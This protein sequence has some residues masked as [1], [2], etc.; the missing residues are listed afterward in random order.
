MAPP[1]KII[2]S[3]DVEGLKQK[4]EEGKKVLHGL[5][6]A[7]LDDSFSKK[8]KKNI[9][10]ELEKGA[11]RIEEDI[12]G[13]RDSLKKMGRAGEAAFDSGKVKSMLGA[14]SEMQVRLKDIKSAQAGM[15]GGAGGAGGGGGMGVGGA[16]RMAKGGLGMV[17]GILGVGVGAA[18]LT[19]RQ[20]GVSQENLRIRALTGG[21]TVSGESQFG[22]T[23]Q[24]RRQRAAEIA[25]SIGRDI[26]A[27][28]LNKVTDMGEK[29]ERAF[30]ITS[31]DQVGAMAAA[32]RAGGQGEEFFSNAIGVA[33]ASGLEGGRV[34][35]FLQSMTQSL[36][37]MS[38][39]VN[40]DTASL[41]GFAGSLASMPFFKS[42][43][44][45]VGRTMQTLNQTF[46]SGDKFQQ[47]M[48]A[49]AIRSAAPSDT[50]ISP[51]SIEVRR[52]LGLFGGGDDDKTGLM[53]KIAKMPGGGADF[54]KTLKIGGGDIIR[55]MFEESTSETKN[56][57]VGQ[58]AQEFMERMS[59]RSQAG[60]E[61]FVKQ[62]L[63][64]GVTEKDIEIARTAQFSPEKRLENAFIGLDKTMVGLKSEVSR[65]ADTMA[66]TLTTPAATAVEFLGKKLSDS[67]G[68]SFGFDS[69]SLRVLG[70]DGSGKGAAAESLGSRLMGAPRGD[71]KVPEI[72]SEQTKIL[73]QIATAAS[74]KG[75]KPLPGSVE[76]QVRT[77]LGV[78]KN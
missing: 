8:V 75:P 1:A 26:N 70:A 29:A 31:G 64:R 52:M 58:Q 56:L 76:S 74:K 39:G 5:G 47:A 23:T 45:R 4:V 65:L 9:F 41:N 78:G 72:L 68:S 49:R 62:K 25:K 51:A 46:Q 33:V 77:A 35:E 22:F 32:R 48:V 13:V 30:G 73:R 59:M 37:E 3:A 6:S 7:G 2:L 21:A 34:G 18:A 61:L 55:Q 66:L 14:L 53:G 67:G 28:E 27:E 16:L 12:D 40:I 10:D 69:R 38:K 44:A 57:S 50:N 60:L 17:A 71:G 15:S 42:D 54:A 20:F 63:G 43:P 36:T 24:E 11:K 19:Q